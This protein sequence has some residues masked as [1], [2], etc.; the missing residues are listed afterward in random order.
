MQVKS[1][2]DDEFLRT[3][4]S[5]ALTLGSPTGSAYDP[6]EN[7][8]VADPANDR[9]GKYCANS[10]DGIVI[11]A[12][13]NGVFTVNGASSVAFDSNNSLYISNTYAHNVAKFS[14]L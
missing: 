2:T 5:T 8:Y 10:T 11:A 13:S 6:Y 3:V 7:L 9:A 12:Y 14:L 4:N 1:I